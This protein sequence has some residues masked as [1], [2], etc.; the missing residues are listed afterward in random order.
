M[1]IEYFGNN[2]NGT[3]AQSPNGSAWS[4]DNVNIIYTCPGS[5]TMDVK[6]LGARVYT[7]STGNIRMAIYDTSKN[8]ICQGNAEIDV[9]GSGSNWVSHTSFTGTAQLTGGTAYLL[10]ITA[11]SSNVSCWDDTVT[12]GYIIRETG[13]LTGGFSAT[14]TLGSNDVRKWCIRCGVEAAA[15]PSGGKGYLSSGYWWNK[16]NE[17]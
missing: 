7:G 16:I 2:A 1:A 5:G 10:V 8:L 9:N 13:E 4:N 3:D 12:S 14:L 11:D 6:E 17:L 15:A